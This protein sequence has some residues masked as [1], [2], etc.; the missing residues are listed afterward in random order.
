MTK[1]NTTKSALFFRVMVFVAIHVAT[2]AAILKIEWLQSFQMAV[3]VIPAA[4]YFT[5]FFIEAKSRIN[6]GLPYDEVW[7]GCFW[8]SFWAGAS[9]TLPFIIFRVGPDGP[10]KLED[11]SVNYLLAYPISCAVFGGLTGL[12]GTVLINQFYG[13]LGGNNDKCNS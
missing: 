6:K 9:L 3:L 1:T 4:S 13:A 5:I 7:R 11:L 12:I 8:F 2:F 10:I